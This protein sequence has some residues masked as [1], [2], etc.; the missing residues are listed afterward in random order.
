LQLG[1]PRAQ[2]VDVGLELDDALHT[3]QVDTL[4]LG[5]SLHLAEPR[6]VPGRVAAAAARRTTW[7]D[8]AEPVVLAQRL[9]VHPGERRRDR[10]H[11][12]GRV[13]RDRAEPVAH[14]SL[15]IDAR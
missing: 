10:D 9:R 8:Q 12:D 5:Q 7:R 14:D 6:N 1:D 11:E 13:L 3:G 4:V 15:T 2:R